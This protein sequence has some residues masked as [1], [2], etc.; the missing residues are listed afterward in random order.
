MPQENV[1]VVRSF[2]TAF[3]AGDQDRW[4]ALL[5]PDVVIVEAREFPGATDRY[6]RDAAVAAIADWGLAW[7]E[8]SFAPDVFEEHGARVLAIGNMHMRG[9]GTGMELESPAAVWFTI[10]DGA[11]ERVE[12]YLDVEEGRRR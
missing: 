9:E 5:S 10:A 2:L 11:I 8:M 1:D 12:F 7:S 3:H 4:V 6:G